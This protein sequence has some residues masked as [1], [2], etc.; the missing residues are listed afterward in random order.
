MLQATGC[1]DLTHQALWARVWNTG[2]SVKVVLGLLG[3][4]GRLVKY[5]LGT[6]AWS[7]WPMEVLREPSGASLYISFLSGVVKADFR[8]FN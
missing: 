5:D 6:L 4:G 8:V 7:S 3:E 2:S 1:L